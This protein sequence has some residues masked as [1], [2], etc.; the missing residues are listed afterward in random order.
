MKAI[1][2]GRKKAW[3]VDQPVPMPQSNEVVVKLHVSLICGSNMA[4]FFSEGEHINNGHEGAGEVVAVAHSHRLKPGDR[5]ALAPLNA[6]GKCADCLAGDV[7]FCKQRPPIHG[8]FAQYTRVADVMCTVLP[9][10][11]DYLLGSL[12]GCGL[13]PAYEGIRSVGLTAFDTLLI[14][15]LGPVGMGAVALAAFMGAEIIAIDPEKCRRD[16]AAQL[17]AAIVLDGSDPQ[18][19]P[20]IM[21]ATRGRGIKKGIDC[22]GKEPAERLL[23]DLAATRA[24]LAFVGENAGTISISPSKDFIRKGLTLSGCWHMNMN[25]MPRLI[26][27]L[28]RA[29]DR[30][31][32]L[33]THQ[34]GF[35]E[36]QKAFDRFASRQCSKVALLP[37]K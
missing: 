17:G 19:K 12:L 20:K 29:P 13:G 35:S 7:I 6:C 2:I 27:F 34:F 26:E 5:V 28:Q 10:G 21:E 4:G 11:I 32:K 33:I 15:G 25:D 23:I 22:T 36:A 8:N 31:G 24:K 9:D 3:L 30:A 16:R 14:T 37:W 1:A 18:I